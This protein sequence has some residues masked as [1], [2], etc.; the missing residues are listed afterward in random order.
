MLSVE[1]VQEEAC[2]QYFCEQKEALEAQGAVKKV[3]T[4]DELFCKTKSKPHIYYLP[5]VRKEAEKE[6]Q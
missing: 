3:V 4:L 6:K 2:K 5:V 1:F